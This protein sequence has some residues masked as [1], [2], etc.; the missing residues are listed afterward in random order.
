[1]R[2]TGTAIKILNGLKYKPKLEANTEKLWSLNAMEETGGEPDV[3][4]LIK[5]PANIF[6][7]IVQRKALKAAEVFVTIMK[8]LRKGRNLNRKI[9]LL[10]WLLIWVLSF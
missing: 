3:V 6:F 2:K 4:G 8:R 7:M 1:L 9:A 5:R 10:I